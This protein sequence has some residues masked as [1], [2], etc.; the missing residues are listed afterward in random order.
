MDRRAELLRRRCLRVVATEISVVGLVAIRAPIALELA[1]VRVEDNDELVLVAVGNEGLVRLWI[2][3]D[4]G[5]PAEVLE[6]V[7]ADSLALSPN[8]HQQLAT[9]GE[10]EDVGVFFTVAADPDVVLV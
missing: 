1:R 7:A 10:L 9:F 3:K 8:L 5:D 2:D 4:L 6:I